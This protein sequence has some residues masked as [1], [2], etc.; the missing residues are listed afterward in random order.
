MISQYNLE[1]PAMGP[2]TSYMMVLTRQASVQG[3]LVPQFGAKFPQG[4]QQMA[5]WLNVG[6]LTYREDVLEGLE[7]TPKAFIRM[8]N[9]EN[10]GKQL[11]KVS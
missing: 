2:R 3:F 8:L 10:K 11:V 6:K 4:I 9:G 7:N 1:K 5:Q